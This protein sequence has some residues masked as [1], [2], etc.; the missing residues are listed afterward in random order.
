MTMAASLEG[1]VPFLDH[2][3]VEYVA[4]IP[5]N[6]KIRNLTTKYI[7]KEAMRPTLPGPIIDRRKHGFGV[8]IGEWFKDELRDYANDVFQDTKTTQRGYFDASYSRK[9]LEEHQKGLQDYSPQLWTLLM[10]EL[11]CREYLDA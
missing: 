3:F 9:L 11:W 1:R 6:L 4:S 7:F 8:P 2:E 5:S 10:F